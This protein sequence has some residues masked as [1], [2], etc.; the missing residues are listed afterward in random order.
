MAEAVAEAAMGVLL[1]GAEAPVVKGLEV[2]SAMT[3]P[4]LSR[5]AR[6]AQTGFTAATEVTAEGGRGSTASAATEATPKG[7]A[8]LT[9]GRVFWDRLPS[10]KTSPN[11]VSQVA[12]SQMDN[13]ESQ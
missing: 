12:E 2:R 5:I 10:F 4:C 11:A 6:L 9:E 1:A 7:V 3:A 13:R 8:Y